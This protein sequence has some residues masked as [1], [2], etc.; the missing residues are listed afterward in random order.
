MIGE[1]GGAPERSDS[2]YLGSMSWPRAIEGQPMPP[3]ILCAGVQASGAI[4]TDTTAVPN[5]LCQQIRNEVCLKV[6]G[7]T[8]VADD[9]LLVDNY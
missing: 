8:V 4:P 9:A 3:L 1:P 2:P 7:M 6:H 5:L